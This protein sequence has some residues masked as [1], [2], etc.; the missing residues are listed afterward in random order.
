MKI[1]QLGKAY[2]PVNLGGVEVVIALLTEG[3]NNAGYECDALGVND[4]YSFVEERGRFGGKIF[5]T[6]LIIKAFSTLLSTQLIS[7]L[8]N[9][10]NNY[11]IIH[12]HSPDPMAALALYFCKPKAK[13]VLHW[14]SDILKQKLLL[15][16]YNPLLNWL[17]KRA[18]LVIATSPTYIEGSKYLIKHKNKTAVLPIGIDVNKQGQPMSLGEARVK[19]YKGKKIIFSLG[20]L[21]YYKG[22]EYLVL[23]ALYLPEN[24]IIVIA[25]EGNEKDRLW[26]LIKENNLFDKVKLIGKVTEE[27]KQWY[28]ENSALFALSSIYKT[29]AYAIVQ[30]EAMAYGL[31]IVS[32]QIAGSG[33]DWVN[34]NGH[35]GLTVPIKDEKAIA[36][37]IS[38][39]LN[40]NELLAN[41]K[42]N[43]SERY[44]TMFTLD[45]MIVQQIELY[46]TL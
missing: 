19:E 29:E 35:T 28:F 14:H 6:K 10:K 34:Q 18:D 3:L 39:I 9:I 21:A 25:G 16:F 13:V 23:A 38:T 11:D 4:T 40:D 32:T 24:F 26:S 36:S 43:A 31:P 8:N 17:L 20:R 7:Y 15:F 44:N 1:L 30:V 33:V 41:F 2:P 42:K 37:A 46:H 5:R 12:I 22:F 45:R 27:A